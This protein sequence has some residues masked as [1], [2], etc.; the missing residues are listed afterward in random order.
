[1]VVRNGGPSHRLWAAGGIQVGSHYFNQDHTA[2]I[3][4][5]SFLLA[6]SGRVIGANYDAMSLTQRHWTEG[7]R[8]RLRL[9]TRGCPEGGSPDAK[10]TNCNAD[11]LILW[12]L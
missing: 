12:P 3:P 6:A 11:G 8:M 1:M 2:T 9:V 5:R 7:G 4:R 10:N